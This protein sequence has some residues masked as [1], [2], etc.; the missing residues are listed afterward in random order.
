MKNKI[1]LILLSCSSALLLIG[2]ITTLQ[3]YKPKNPSEVPIK[4][5]LVKWETTWNSNDV[6]GNLFLWNDKARI[7]YGLD[8]KFATKQEYEK[9]LPERIKAH[10]IIKLGPPRINIS[11]NKADVSLD[12]SLGDWK[13]AYK[14]LVIF[15]LVRENGAWS[16]IGW[17]Y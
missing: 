6:N 17:E 7:M 1:F 13:G 2:C 4:A 15:H 12:M 16:I 5:L 3:A 8:R 9:I 14:L 11:G 10:P